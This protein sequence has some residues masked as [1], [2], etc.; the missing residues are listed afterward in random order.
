MNEEKERIYKK[1]SSFLNN[2]EENIIRLF[3]YVLSYF[4][5]PIDLKTFEAVVPF[6]PLKYFTV[7][8]EDNMFRITPIFPTIY[9]I[10]QE[11]LPKLVS[12]HSQ[13][14]F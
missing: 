7:S 4:K 13:Q 12:T 14:F 11:K 2:N 9:S 3:L 1:I 6:V 5:S 8:K 10:I